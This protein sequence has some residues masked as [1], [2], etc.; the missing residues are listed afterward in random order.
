MI[1]YFRNNDRSRNK[2]NYYVWPIITVF[3]SISYS[4]KMSSLEL[5]S[6]VPM[7]VVATMKKRIYVYIT[8]IQKVPVDSQKFSVSYANM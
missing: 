6:S 7:L 2:C 3:E 1:A 8:L 4:G 5:T